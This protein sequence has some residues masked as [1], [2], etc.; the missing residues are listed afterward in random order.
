MTAD[1]ALLQL[2][3]YLRQ[4]DYRFTAVT[5][6]THERVLARPAPE[7]RDLRD[8][9]G[10]S[11]PFSQQDADA[12]LLD[13]MRQAEVLSEQGNGLVKSAVRVAS[14][15]DALFIHSAF[16]TNEPD[17][18]FFGPDSYRFVRF[19]EARLPAKAGVRCLADMGTGSGVGGIM[20]ARRCAAER[21]ILVDINPAALRIAEVNGAAAGVAVETI[22][23]DRVPAEPDL[24]IAN[25]PFLMD[26][27][28][29]A[30]RD[31][32]ALFGGDV[33]LGWARQFLEEPAPGRTF[34]LYTAFAYVGGR[35]PLLDALRELVAAKG[36]R[37]DGEE[38]D[39]DVFGEELDRPQYRIVE[40]I[41]AVGKTIST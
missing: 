35:S 26:E 4:R 24:V 30:Y 17:A 36:A 32:G 22:Q 37:L 27:A 31:G 19:V 6:A 29:R 25:A 11:R 2:L 18:V 15:D 16:P 7:Q 40:R 39:P 10:W 23:S 3:Q 9:F 13:L 21:T 28:G 38:I 20:L 5:P 34:L 1:A 14:L 12:A 33:S 41:A 8:I